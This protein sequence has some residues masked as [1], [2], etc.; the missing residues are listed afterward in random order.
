MG[1]KKATAKGGADSTVLENIQRHYQYLEDHFNELN[2]A[3]ATDEQRDALRRDYLNAHKVYLAAYDA[4]INEDD[5]HVEDLNEEISSAQS[6]IE[7]MEIDEENVAKILDTV[8]GIVRT[9]SSL[10]ALAGVVA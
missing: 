5:Q 1:K 6:D 2:A 8:T 7:G 3:C 4:V 10:L 9:A